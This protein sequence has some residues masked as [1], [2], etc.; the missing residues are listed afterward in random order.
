MDE[1]TPICG[2]CGNKCKEQEYAEPTWFGRYE[3]DR[4]IEAICIDCWKKGE[5]WDKK[6]GV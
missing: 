3:R 2:R 4:L 1:K 6:M 5:K